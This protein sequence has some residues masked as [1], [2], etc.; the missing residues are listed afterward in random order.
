M[1]AKEKEAVDEMHE[2]DDV[3]EEKEEDDEI[4]DEGD[5]EDDEDEDEWLV[6]CHACG[7]GW[8]GRERKPNVTRAP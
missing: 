3:V 4:L 2:K 6:W 5:G 8:A 7:N 1:N